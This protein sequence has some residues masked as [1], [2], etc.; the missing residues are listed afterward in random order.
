M[1]QLGFHSILDRLCKTALVAL[2][3]L[4]GSVAATELCDSATDRIFIF[5]EPAPGIP[6]G[7]QRCYAT[8]LPSAG[9]WLVDASASLGADVR[10]SLWISATPCDADEEDT[11]P[12]LQTLHRTAGSAL[13]R[14]LDPGRYLFCVTARDPGQTLGRHWVSSLFAPH[15]VAGD[16]DED[17]PDPRPLSYRP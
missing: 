14:V 4:P 10:P 5:N 1:R 6:G 3:S 11:G 9:V 15:A 7:G 8:E 12:F 13:L 16:P 2:L 17:E